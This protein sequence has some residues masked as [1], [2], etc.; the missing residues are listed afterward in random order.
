MGKE[1]IQLTSEVAIELMN[2]PNF[3][4]SLKYGGL[5][6]C[7]LLLKTL[8]SRFTFLRVQEHPVLRSVIQAQLT[9]FSPSYKFL[10]YSDVEVPISSLMTKGVDAFHVVCA[11]FY[12]QR[13]SVAPKTTTGAEVSYVR[14]VVITYFFDCIW[15]NFGG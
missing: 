9:N 14:E 13:F 11:G 12:I 1:I 5:R 7:R 10:S 15:H 2:R 8:V 3:F 6:I 4:R